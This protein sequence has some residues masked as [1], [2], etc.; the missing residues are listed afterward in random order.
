MPITHTLGVTLDEKQVERLDEMVEQYNRT[1]GMTR[2]PAMSREELIVVALATLEPV[3]F[4]A[5]PV[6]GVFDPK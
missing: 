5:A 3:L 4:P 2:S 6:R 1:R